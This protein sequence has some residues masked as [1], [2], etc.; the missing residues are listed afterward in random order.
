MVEMAKT[1]EGKPPNADEK[2]MAAISHAGIIIGGILVALIV[3][4]VQKD[5]SKYVGFQAK[6][7]L[8]YQ[9]VV[10]VGEGILGVVVFV[11]G[12]LT[13]GIGFFILVPLLVIIGLGTLVYGLYAAYKTYSGEEF[14]YWIIADVLEKK[15]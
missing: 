15:T 14:R 4:L 1:S 6:Q 3:W 8:V 2:L 5:K 10:L 13:F 12:V 11:L 9:L 7:A